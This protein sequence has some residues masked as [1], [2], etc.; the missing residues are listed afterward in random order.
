MKRRIAVA[1]IIALLVGLLAGYL[2]W[3]VRTQRQL[4]EV[5]GQM[6]VV[7]SDLKAAQDKIKALEAELRQERD[8]RQKLE[9]I[10]TK[11]RK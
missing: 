7:Q 6:L 9:E 8:R 5:Q 1:A 10:V 2:L 4:N 11:G 3:G